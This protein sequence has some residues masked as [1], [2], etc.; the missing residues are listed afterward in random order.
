MN[1]ADSIHSRDLTEK[2]L[3]DAREHL[4]DELRCG[5]KVNGLTLADLL[6]CD[7]NDPDGSHYR[8]IVEDAA[9]ALWS[10]D[11]LIREQANTRLTDGL[12]KR[13]LSS[14]KC[15]Y[16]VRDTAEEMLHEEVE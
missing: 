9:S 8:S 13:Y 7:L 5:R 6:E 4:A 12:I 15:E 16:F 10:E 14:P 3:A 1:L 2:D 11:S